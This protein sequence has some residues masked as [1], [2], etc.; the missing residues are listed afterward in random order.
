MRRDSFIK[1]AVGAKPIVTIRIGTEETPALYDTGSQVT[2]VTESYYREALSRD[3][4][5]VPHQWSTLTAANGLQ[6]PIVGYLV[7]SVTVR[8][9]LVE[10]VVIMVTRRRRIV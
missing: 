3:L 10:D 8:E 6:I 4:L 1:K 7:T 2:T 9:E 5:S